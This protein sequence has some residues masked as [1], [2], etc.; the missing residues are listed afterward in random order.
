MQV[1]DLYAQLA[2]LSGM[3]ASG[4]LS[5]ATTVL[6]SEDYG[7]AIPYLTEYLERMK[8]AEACNSAGTRI[9]S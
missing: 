2:E 8:R 6:S 5:E 3:S 4:L 7:A 9:R 1:V